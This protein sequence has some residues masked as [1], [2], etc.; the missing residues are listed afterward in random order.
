MSINGLE[1]Y[2]FVL[3]IPLYILYS[4]FS[5]FKVYYDLA[6]RIEAEGL[7]EI[8][9]DGV[10][11]IIP[12]R[13]E[14]DVIEECINSI[15][16][17]SSLIREIVVINDQSND[18]TAA[19]VRKLMELDSRIKL[20]EVDD[21]PVGWTGKNYALYKGAVSVDAEWLFFIDA[22]V[23]IAKNTLQYVISYMENNNI[24]LFSFSPY[25]ICK[26]FYEQLMQPTMFNLINYLYPLDEINTE[27]SNLY[28]VNGAFI[29]IRKDDY[30]RLGG[31]Q[32]IKNKV[33][34]DVEL[35]KIAW[36]KGY[37]VKLMSGYPLVRSRMYR[38]FIDLWDGWSKNIYLLIKESNKN[39]L[40][41]FL[42]NLLILFYPFFLFF[43]F[44][45]ILI[46][47]IIYFA[48]GMIE[49]MARYRNKFSWQY[50]MLYSISRFMMLLIMLNS[51]VKANLLKRVIWKRRSY[52][53]KG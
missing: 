41:L 8:G 36:G 52:R 42:R 46:S 37:R 7:D 39:F 34:E 16:N 51:Y 45:Q 13:N 6:E 33:L 4:E 23:I 9:K 2:I 18:N 14:E 40:L 47:L 25:Q 50:G 31:H 35:A 3:F 1:M 30:I 38:N 12:A 21:L 15:Q 28:A 32:I 5:F 43:I 24:N 26:R 48:I 20:I 29:G 27:N 49:S 11:C 17:D 19:I 53:I 10:V 22:D 44:D